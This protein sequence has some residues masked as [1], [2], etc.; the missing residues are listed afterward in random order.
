MY[1]SGVVGPLQ[2]SRLAESGLNAV[3]RLGVTGA[4]AVI[5]AA[6]LVA[7]VVLAVLR[8]LLTYGNLVLLRRADV[9][10]LRHGLLRLRERTYDMSRLPAGRCDS[11]CWCAPSAAVDSTR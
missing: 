10:H 1:E 7:S 8:S 6:V 9:L 5:A 2:H 4:V 11:R 3:Q